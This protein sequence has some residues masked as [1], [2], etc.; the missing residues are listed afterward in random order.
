[1]VVVFLVFSSFRFP[2]PVTVRL[3]Q[4][5]PELRV[6]GVGGSWLGI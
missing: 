6:F 4:K 1:M 2:F 5:G 3:R